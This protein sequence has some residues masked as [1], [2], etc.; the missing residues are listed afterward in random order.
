[1]ENLIG[2]KVKGFKFEG[3]FD[4]SY[5][6]EMDKK[7]GEVGKVIIIEDDTFGVEFKN[8]QYWY[9]LSE[10]EKHL[11]EENE[12]EV[13][14]AE[15]VTP[16]H[17]NNENGTLYKVANDRNWNHYLFDIVNRLERAEKKGE[18]KSDL[19][20]SINIIQLWLKESKNE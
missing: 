8:D 3:C 12:I 4:L 5:L 1:M 13:N 14:D 2:R 19:Q 11:V 18:F 10:I 17:Y 7:I 6:S 16:S 9:P 15:I 20:K